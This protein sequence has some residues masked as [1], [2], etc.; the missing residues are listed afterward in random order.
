M[1]IWSGYKFSNISKSFQENMEHKKIEF[2]HRNFSEDTGSKMHKKF[3]F[4]ERLKNDSLILI[5]Y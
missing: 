4:I 2:K 3:F 5:T 1:I